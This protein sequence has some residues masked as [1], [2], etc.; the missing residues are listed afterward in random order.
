M[1]SHHLHN[2]IVIG[3]GI[4]GMQHLSS[5]QLLPICLFKGLSGAK[6]LAEKGIDVLVLEA[7]DRVGGRTWTVQ[8][9]PTY[10]SML[11]QHSSIS[12]ESQSKMGRSWRCLYWPRAKLSFTAD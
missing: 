2:V 12:T 10:N 3:A 4:S 11:F 9:G 6:L 8:V 5:L 7:R 1:S